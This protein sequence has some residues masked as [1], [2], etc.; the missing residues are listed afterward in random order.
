[1]LQ[2]GRQACRQHWGGEGLTMNHSFHFSV[3]SAS[4]ALPHLGHFILVNVVPFESA[5]VTG[6]LHPVHEYQSCLMNV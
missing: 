3:V 5:L 2:K 6:P 4:I 1:M